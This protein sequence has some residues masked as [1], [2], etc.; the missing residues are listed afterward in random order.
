[1]KVRKNSVERVIRGGSFDYVSRELRV[2]YRERD[3]PERGIGIDGFRLV[4]RKKT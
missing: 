2:T 1:V 4:I 3:K